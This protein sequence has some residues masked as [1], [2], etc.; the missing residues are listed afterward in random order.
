MD[1][2]VRDM[3][4]L[5]GVRISPVEGFSEIIGFR[6]LGVAEKIPDCVIDLY[7]LFNSLI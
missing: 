4:H 5:R 7:L 3:L 1:G 6:C 2:T